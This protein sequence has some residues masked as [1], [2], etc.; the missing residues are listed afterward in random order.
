M[1]ALW[2]DRLLTLEVDGLLLSRSPF[3][4]RRAGELVW[5]PVRRKQQIVRSIFVPPIQIMQDSGFSLR[6]IAE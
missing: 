2:H 4:R 6:Q 5:C 1:V 3:I